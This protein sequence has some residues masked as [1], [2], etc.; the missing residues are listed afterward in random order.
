MENLFIGFLVFI[1]FLTAFALGR[2]SEWKFTKEEA[3]RLR[4]EVRKAVGVKDKVKITS[5]SKLREHDLLLRD[6]EDG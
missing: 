2:F 1:T 5:P 3:K 6:I 4:K